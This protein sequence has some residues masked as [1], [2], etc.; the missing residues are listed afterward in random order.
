MTHQQFLE[1]L[2]DGATTSNG[3]LNRY[4]PEFVESLLDDILKLLDM[5]VAHAPETS[6]DPGI[7]AGRNIA[8]YLHMYVLRFR[9]WESTPCDALAW[10]TRNLMEMYSWVEHIVA[11][12]DHARS[13]LDEADIDQRELFEVHLRAHDSGENGYEKLV[14]DVAR[15]MVDRIPGKRFRPEVADNRLFKECSKYVHPSS[16]LINKLHA[17]LNDEHMRKKLVAFGLHYVVDMMY[18]LVKSNPE[19]I[20]WADDIEKLG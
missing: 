4:T 11:C 17:R 14:I 3:F 13:F 10:F 16:W 8:M 19:T 9:H 7:I 15:A 20:K 6:S 5:Y 1:Y 18:L 12:S 2:D